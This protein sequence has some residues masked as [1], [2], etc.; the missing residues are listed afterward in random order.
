[1]GF[2]DER[3]DEFDEQEFDSDEFEVPEEAKDQSIERQEYLKK[4]VYPKTFK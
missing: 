4:I 2:D 1:M 3:T